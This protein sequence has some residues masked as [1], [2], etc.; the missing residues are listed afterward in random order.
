MCHT[1]YIKNIIIQ[2]SLYYIAHRSK[3]S[4]EIFRMNKKVLRPERIIP[5]NVKQRHLGVI[6]APLPQ[7]T[8]ET[9]TDLK[10][11]EA[12]F[13]SYFKVKLKGSSSFSIRLFMQFLLVLSHFFVLC[14]MHKT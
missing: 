13:S 9:K 11:A 10:E 12:F 5:K 3:K 4:K 8:L 7:I 6:T 14:R 1:I 2:L